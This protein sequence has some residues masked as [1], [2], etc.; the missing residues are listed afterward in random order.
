[1]LRLSTCALALMALVGTSSTAAVAQAATGGPYPAAC[2]AYRF[3]DPWLPAIPLP[4]VQPNSPGDVRLNPDNPII[5]ADAT[6]ADGNAVLATG[7]NGDAFEYWDSLQQ[8]WINEYVDDSGQSRSFQHVFYATTGKDNDGALMVST[9][10]TWQSGLARLLEQ[11]LGRL[12]LRCNNAA[13][14]SCLQFTIGKTQD[15]DAEVAN[16]PQTITSDC[17]AADPAPS[18][19]SSPSGSGGD[20]STPQEPKDPVDAVPKTPIVDGTGG[21]GGNNDGLN[22]KSAATTSKPFALASA[23]LLAACALLLPRLL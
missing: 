11:R 4:S 8:K 7:C 22:P 21:T 17:L 2:C 14:D 18:Q 13:E 20:G 23:A 5:N 16:R 3:R 1:M 6:G 12:R 9:L 10:Q 15:D 19:P